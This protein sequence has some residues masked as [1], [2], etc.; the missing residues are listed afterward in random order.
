MWSVYLIHRQQLANLKM[1][2][3][4]SCLELTQ[5]TLVDSARHWWCV[6]VKSLTQYNKDMRV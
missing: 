4:H 1:L 2:P 6:I 5:H 3:V